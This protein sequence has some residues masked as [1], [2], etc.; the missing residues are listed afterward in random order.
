[1]VFDEVVNVYNVVMCGGKELAQAQPPAIKNYS[2]ENPEGFQ[3]WAQHL[4][5]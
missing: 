1:M 2:A 5:F 3:Y 4:G